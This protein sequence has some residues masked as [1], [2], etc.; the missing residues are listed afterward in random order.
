M[1]EESTYPPGEA[2]KGEKLTFERLQAGSKAISN[3]CVWAVISPS[4]FRGP[5]WPGEG[6][7]PHSSPPSSFSS[8]TYAHIDSTTLLICTLKMEAEYSCETLITLHTPS[9]SSRTD[10]RSYEIGGPTPYRQEEEFYAGGS[11]SSW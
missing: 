6:T 4:Y 5:Y 8:L 9:V 1:R 10:I 11:V 2:V 7:S 3:R